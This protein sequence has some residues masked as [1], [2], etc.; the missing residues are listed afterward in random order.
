MKVIFLDID[1]V[2]NVCYE[3][4]D[5][6]GQGFHP[7]FVNNLKLIIEATGAKLVISSSWRMSGL[8]TMKNMWEYRNLPG[9]IIDITPD[10]W[11]L[12]RQG[13]FPEDYDR[14]HEIKHWLERNIVENYVIIDDDTDMLP[15][16]LNNFVHTANNRQHKDSVDLGYGLTEECAIKAIKILKS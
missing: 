16:Q 9:E 15:E 6:Y 2:L 14:G 11:I 13:L 8:Q 1:G 10:G 7:S 3:E 12:Y 4:Y 5:K